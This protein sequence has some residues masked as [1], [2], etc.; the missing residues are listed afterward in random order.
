MPTAF[1]AAV[2]RAL[3]REFYAIL[4]QDNDAVSIAHHLNDHFFAKERLITRLYHIKCLQNV[5][6]Q[7]ERPLRTVDGKLINKLLNTLA[8]DERRAWRQRIANALQPVVCLPDVAP[9][10]RQQGARL[11]S[12]TWSWGR[13]LTEQ[14]GHLITPVC[15][16]LVINATRAIYDVSMMIT[17][18]CAYG[19]GNLTG[20]LP[21]PK[22]EPVAATDEQM[23]RDLQTLARIRYEAIAETL[24]TPGSRLTRMD[25]CS[26]T[27]DALQRLKDK[28][29]VLNS[30][31]KMDRHMDEF[32]RRHNRGLVRFIDFFRPINLFLSRTVFR[33]VLHDKALLI[34]EARRFKMT[35]VTI[36]NDMEDGIGDSRQ[37]LLTQAQR[38]RVSA[39]VI[40]ANSHYVFLNRQHQQSAHNAVAELQERVRQSIDTLPLLPAMA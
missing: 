15:P 20:T 2:T 38:V 31:L 27:T 35:L 34:E 12:S 21:P 32:I 16:G 5:L 3:E 4:M 17:E 19:I 18:A 29:N 36:R 37:T 7:D 13:W 23:K 40:R 22:P 11:I 28:L 9:T 6:A 39:S 10:Y 14:A 26:A 25:V 30:L 8:H 24:I 33:C 1:D